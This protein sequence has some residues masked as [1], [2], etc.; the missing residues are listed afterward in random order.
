MYSGTE[1]VSRGIQI[2]YYYLHV[3]I[4]GGMLGSEVLLHLNLCP[5]LSQGW[6]L[7]F[8]SILRPDVGNLN[9][10][11]EIV[12]MLFIVISMNVFAYHGKCQRPSK[13]RTSNIKRYFHPLYPWGAP[14]YGRHMCHKNNHDK[15]SPCMGHLCRRSFPSMVWP[16][17]I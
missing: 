14:G 9:Q 6:N 8:R 17:V 13:L 12:S 11:G 1:E 16:V 5:C 2:K 4:V 15:V 3:T 10:D 7:E